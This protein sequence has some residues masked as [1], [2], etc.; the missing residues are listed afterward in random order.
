MRTCRRGEMPNAEV[1]FFKEAGPEYHL[2]LEWW[3]EFPQ[4]PGSN[5][6][7]HNFYPEL[8]LAVIRTACLKRTAQ[9]RCTSLTAY[10]IHRSQ[11][12]AVLITPRSSDT[13]PDSDQ[14]S[15]PLVGI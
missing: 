4:K 2:S 5:A 12:L 14:L 10:D 1:S 8:L 11:L 7:Q 6:L 13:V 15:L 9:D 3:A